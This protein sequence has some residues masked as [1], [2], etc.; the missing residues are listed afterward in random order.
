MKMNA[1]NRVYIND[2]IRKKKNAEKE[3]YWKFA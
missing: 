3:K 2:S 1:I